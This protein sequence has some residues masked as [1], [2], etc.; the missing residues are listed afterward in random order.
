MDRR[1]HFFAQAICGPYPKCQV[2]FVENIDHASLRI[3]KLGRLGNNGGEHGLQIERGVYRLRYLTECVQ[4]FDGAREF[5]RA[6]SD[7]LVELVDVFSDIGLQEAKAISD[8]VDLVARPTR[9]ALQR[10]WTCEVIRREGGS[11]IGDVLH[12]QL[13]LPA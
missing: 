1:N 11:K 6:L 13:E 9:R 2:Q 10:Q 5:G 4:L 7:E 3:R 8:L 12:R